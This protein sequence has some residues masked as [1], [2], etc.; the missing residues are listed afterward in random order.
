MPG[1]EMGVG[2]S[3]VLL[4]GCWNA[5]ALKVGLTKCAVSLKGVTSEYV[6]DP[7]FQGKGGCHEKKGFFVC[8][9]LCPDVGR[10]VNAEKQKQGLKP[11]RNP[12]RTIQTPVGRE[13]G[14]SG[15]KGIHSTL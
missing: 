3:S 9:K 10:G 15:Q 11:Q 12:S 2:V 13:G 8:L 7:V 5:R 4:L 14:L 6:C 1:P